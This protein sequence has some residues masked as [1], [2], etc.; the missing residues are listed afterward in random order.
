MN[1][2]RPGAVVYLSLCRGSCGGRAFL[3]STC[4]QG[5]AISLKHIRDEDSSRSFDDRCSPTCRCLPAHLKPIRRQTHST[6]ADAVLHLPMT[7]WK[8]SS[9]QTLRYLPKRGT[10]PPCTWTWCCSISISAIGDFR[11]TGPHLCKTRVLRTRGPGAS[12]LLNEYESRARDFY[13]SDPTS[14]CR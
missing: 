8:R 1:P 7:L 3:L 6:L 13:F 14:R 5:A 4:L 2:F 10:E 11:R 9:R 12:C